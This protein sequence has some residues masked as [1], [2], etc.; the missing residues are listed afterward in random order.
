MNCLHFIVEPVGS[1][2]PKIVSA[3]KYKVVE[4]ATSDNATL[5]CPAQSYPVPSYR[6]YFNTLS[7]CFTFYFIK[8]FGQ[9]KNVF[10]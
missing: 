4:S 5:L 6:Y 9:I 8:T 1:V 7:F 3:D 10:F 2:R